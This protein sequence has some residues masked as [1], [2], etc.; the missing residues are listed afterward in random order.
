MRAGQSTSS[1]HFGCSQG[2]NV[3]LNY[4]DLEPG[5]E[6]VGFGISSCFTTLLSMAQLS[7]LPDVLSCKGQRPGG[8]MDFWSTL[9]WMLGLL[10]IMKTFENMV[11]LVLF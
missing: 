3:Y 11:F 6:K 9:T 10:C 2:A 8:H 5:A 4:R 7:D 1:V